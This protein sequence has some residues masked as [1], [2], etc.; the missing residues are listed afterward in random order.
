MTAS[1]RNI[2]VSMHFTAASAGDVALSLPA[3]TPGSYQ[4]GNFARYV[5]GFSAMR[6]SDSL[7]WEKLDPDTWS[8]SVPA[9]GDITVR[10]DYRAD[11]LDN[12]MSWSTRDFAFF[13]GTNLFLHPDGRYDF[14]STVTVRTMPA[15][16]VAT[17]MTLAPGGAD[18]PGS[19]IFAASDY[20]ELVD[21]PFF[22]GRFDID[23]TTIAGKPFR[24]ANRPARHELARGADP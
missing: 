15:W 6:G 21:M 8:V 7:E 20:H 4:L 10:F 13:N 23:S 3:W 17:G 16:S 24:F 22:I 9:A 5:R 11:S 12:A 19:R 18:V 2:G 1:D 14:A